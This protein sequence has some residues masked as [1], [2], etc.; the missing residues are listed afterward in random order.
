MYKS[1]LWEELGASSP[2]FYISTGA[3]AP[4]NDESIY[5]FSVKRGEN[6]ADPGISINSAQFEVAEEWADVVGTRVQIG[7]TPYGADLVA[8]A[9]GNTTAAA[10]RERFWG[11]TGI[12]SVEDSPSGR[13]TT[14]NCASWLA[15]LKKSKYQPNVTS[16]L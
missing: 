14:V 10:I 13:S 9:A 3:K 4:V 16:S 7:L 2:I 11:R 1:T 8:K 12:A 6:T 5:S 15:E